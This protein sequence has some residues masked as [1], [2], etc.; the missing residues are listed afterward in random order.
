MSGRFVISLA[1]WALLAILTDDQGREGFLVKS[2]GS[3]TP[4]RLSSLDLVASILA[5]QFAGNV[6]RFTE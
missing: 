2:V 6:V 3:F 5:D 1:L 4:V